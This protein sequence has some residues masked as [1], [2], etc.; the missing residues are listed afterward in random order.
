MDKGKKSSV[1][2][3]VLISMVIYMAIIAG[4]VAV[5]FISILY[6]NGQMHIVAEQD[7][8]GAEAT[9]DEVQQRIYGYYIIFA[10]LFGGTI[11][12]TVYCIY[13][14][15]NHIQ[16]P[17][18]ILQKAAYHLTRTGNLKFPDEMVASMKK[19]SKTGDEISNVIISFELMVESLQKK[20]D[21]LETVARGDLRKRVSLSSGEDYLGIAVNDVVTNLSTIVRDVITATEQ[22]SV[23]AH[24]LSIGAQSLSQSSSE[25]SATMDNLHV[26][27]GEIA[28]EAAENA[29][30]AAEA[31]GLTAKI[32]DGAAEGGRKMLDMTSAM[33]EINKASHSIGSVMKV[34]DE[35][36]FQT[37]ILALNA[38]VEAARAGVHG[39]GFAV[40][41][42]EVRNLATKSGEAAND[43]NTMI[44]DTITKSEMGTR[45]VDDAIAFFKT[46]EEGIANI[47]DLLDEIA[48]AAKS[49]SIAIEQ[50]N[51]SLT[52]MTNVVYHNSA[53]SEQSAAASEQMN[54]QA[55]LLKETVNRFMLE[56]DHVSV[57][58]FAA[59]DHVPESAP[60]VREPV[61]MIPDF[62][63]RELEFNPTTAPSEN[64]GL[65]PA[66]IYAKA[67]ARETR[68]EAESEPA[69]LP[70]P[71]PRP[72]SPVATPLSGW[73]DP[74]V[75]NGFKDDDSKY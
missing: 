10:C 17:L 62:Q 71:E 23:G 44:A 32:R 43:T 27:A 30:R 24:E 54:S 48:K 73:T 11:A 60:P 8:A 51:N 31:S 13:S 22:L 64:G 72:M 12:F 15:A 38:A 4:V 21:V 39:K 37:N 74:K 68:A 36:A 46:V 69:P 28:S 61:A 45:I 35:I 58:T 19:Y 5:A 65:S 29:E 3:R 25:Q 40:V 41:A 14:I 9:M 49:Q 20:V 47:N 26:T 75:G 57:L 59:E 66:E 18:G 56:D 6:I 7:G 50:V 1:R 2:V 67:L 33:S 42:D 63:V 55:L 53:T 34:I 70:P 52:E 16:H